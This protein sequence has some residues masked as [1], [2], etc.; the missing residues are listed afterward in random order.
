MD[1]PPDALAAAQ[2]ALRKD[3]FVPE[4]ADKVVAL[5]WRRWRSYE[6]RHKKGKGSWE[7]RVADLTTG[8]RA[9]LQNKEHPVGDGDMLE[10]RHVASLLAN[11][12]NKTIPAGPP[13]DR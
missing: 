12:C 4:V 9:Q 5:G 8:P 6:R 7:E 1:L 13:A 11:V 10:Y 2:A 3:G